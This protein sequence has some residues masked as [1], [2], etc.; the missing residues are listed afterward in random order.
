MT[1][2]SCLYSLPALLSLTDQNCH[3]SLAKPLS[4]LKIHSLC[5]LLALSWQNVWEAQF[6]SLSLFV[7]LFVCLFVVVFFFGG[8]L[9]NWP[10]KDTATE[11]PDEQTKTEASQSS[12]TLTAETTASSTSSSAVS[13]TANSITGV[14][15]S[16]IQSHK[17]WGEISSE[18]SGETICPS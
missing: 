9:W 7:C 2:T 17:S 12:V 11:M 18:I 13:S 6:L 10:V 16:A 14:P 5:P 8:G 1:E 4:T 3:F 15:Q